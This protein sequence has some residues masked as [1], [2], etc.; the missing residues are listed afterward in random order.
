MEHVIKW[1][2]IG[3]GGI[4][5]K[6]MIPAVMDSDNTKIIIVQDINENLA[7]NTGVKFGINW[8]TNV[9]DVLDNDEVEAVYIATPVF[10]H[11][12]LCKKASNS[13]KHILCEKPFS[14]DP[15]ECFKIKNICKNNNVLFMNAFMMRFH[16][17]HQKVKQIIESGGI[18][19]I[20]MA[21]AQL[22]HYHV[23]YGPSNEFTWRTDKKLAGGGALMDMGI[24]CVDLLRWWIGDITEVSGMIDTIIN[25]Y[26]VE[27]TGIG[28]LKFKNGAI[29]LVDSTFCA[30]GAKHMF[31]IYGTN[32]S[33]FGEKTIGQL[34]EGKMVMDIDG[35][36]SEY[37]YEPNNMYKQ[38]VEYFNNCIIQ[39]EI[40]MIDADEAY[41][42]LLVVNAIY[43]SSKTGKK[44]TLAPF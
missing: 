29:G 12:D 37:V 1:G 33:L 30:K 40:P 44:I 17:V 22:S 28:L 43:E 8:T 4:A 10:T 23:E 21:R 39:N 11:F 25:H 26:S 2:V 24:H 9:N 3:C 19:R 20:V 6:R 41:K 7:K 32:G 15:N 18:G 35:N 5:Y 27:D 36:I 42:N 34:P 13:K 14:I 38:E 31:E 16:S